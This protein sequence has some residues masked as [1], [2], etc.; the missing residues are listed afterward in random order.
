MQVVSTQSEIQVTIT[1]QEAEART[2]YAILQ[3][4]P[5]GDGLKN[6]ESAFLK[7]ELV[8][9]YNTDNLGYDAIANYCNSLYAKLEAILE[10]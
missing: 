6:I 1:L 8:S 10:K 5:T 4:I 2:L 9:V 3:A 7:S